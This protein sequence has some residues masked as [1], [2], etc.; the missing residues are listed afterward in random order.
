MNDKDIEEFEKFIERNWGKQKE[1]V[2]VGATQEPKK[3]G[4]KPK[5]A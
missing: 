3:R 2:T 4:R 5:N 1:V